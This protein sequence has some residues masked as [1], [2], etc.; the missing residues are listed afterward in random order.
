KNPG[1]ISFS[2]PGV[3]SVWDLATRRIMV[4][5]DTDFSSIPFDGSAPAV[6]AA[7]SEHVDFTTS[8]IGLLGP[9]VTGGEMRFLAMLTEERLDD[10]PDVPT[11]KEL[12][13]DVEHATWVGMMAP[14]DTPDDIVEVLSDAMTA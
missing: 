12:G 9:Q 11:A 1:E 5:T 6:H 13:I 7:S 4:E 10:Y 2:S 3:G 8:A 14:A